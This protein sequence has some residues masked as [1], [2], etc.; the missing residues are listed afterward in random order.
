MQDG[1][2]GRGEDMSLSGGQW[3]TEEGD[4]WNSAASQESSSSCNS[5]GNPSKKGPQKV[6]RTIYICYYLMLNFQHNTCALYW[7]CVAIIFCH[8][9][10]HSQGKV[11]GKQEDAWIMNRLTKQLTDMGFPV[12]W[13][14]CCGVH[15]LGQTFQYFW[16]SKQEAN[17]WF[18]DL[19]HKAGTPLDGFCW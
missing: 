12:S 3:D 11:T 5:W 14:Y 17:D 4:M 7:G 19:P 1:W 8:C 15:C 13:S 2:G 16:M 9:L 18:H 6:W 10:L